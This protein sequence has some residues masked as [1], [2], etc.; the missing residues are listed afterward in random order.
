MSMAN[1]DIQQFGA[2]PD[3]RDPVLLAGFAGWNDAGQVATHALQTLTTAWS[4]SRFAEIEPENYFDF[5]E[6]RPIVS[7]TPTGQ[8][9]LQWPANSFFAHRM[10]SHERDVVLLIGT[11]PQLHWKSFCRNVMSIAEGVNASCLVTLG[12]LLADVPHTKEPTLSGFASTPRLLP[13]LQQ[14]GVGLSSYEGPT[15]ILGVLHDA[16]SSTDRPAISLWG[17]VPH[18]ISATPNPQV[19]L[20]LLRRLAILLGTTLPLV[21]LESQARSFATQVDE[22]LQENV[23]AQEYVRQLEEQYDEEEEEPPEATPALMEALEEFL[24]TK[25]PS[26]EG[27]GL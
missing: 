1:H 8:R 12:G 13:Q 5:T 2:T 4:A 22:A 18:Y 11:E 17:N 14:M 16:W 21:T 9:S 6:T 27:E 26:D 10:P 15:G 3:L 19:S 24:R 20:A 25:R 23:E 7:L